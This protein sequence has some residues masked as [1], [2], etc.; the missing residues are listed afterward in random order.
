[1]INYIWAGLAL[2]VVCQVRA[3][4]DRYL[5]DV[6][7]EIK[8]RHDVA[9]KLLDFFAVLILKLGVASD[10]PNLEPEP[11]VPSEGDLPN[12]ESEP[13]PIGPSDP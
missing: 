9:T 5:D 8:Q 4:C 7:R 6:A 11:I 12:M 10:L 1:M 3:L 2:I 13:E